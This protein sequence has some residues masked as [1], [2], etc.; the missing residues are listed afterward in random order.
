MAI[1]IHYQWRHLEDDGR[2]TE[3]D[4]KGPFYSPDQLN[5]AQFKSEQ[6]AIDRAAEFRQQW[7]FA[8]MWDLTLV[9]VY[10]FVED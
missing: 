9:K 10:S 3:P 4:G 6:E 2:L 1:E 5:S 7:P 8:R